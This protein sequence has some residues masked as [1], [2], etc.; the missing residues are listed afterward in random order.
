MK[1]TTLTTQRQN[2]N[3]I[4]ILKAE[5]KRLE[6]MIKRLSSELSSHYHVVNTTTDSLNSGMRTS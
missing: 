5:I 6:D 2:A 1:I 4:Q 3:D